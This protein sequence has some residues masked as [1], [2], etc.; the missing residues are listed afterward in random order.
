MRSVLVG[1]LALASCA[2]ANAW[3][4]DSARAVA[5]DEV[6]ASAVQAGDVPGAVALVITRDSVLYH[7]AFGLMDPVGEVM[8]GDAI[9]RIRSMTKPMTS[10]GIMML[11][12][13]GLIALDDPASRHLPELAGREVLVAVD[14]VERSVT[15]RPASREVTVRDLLR[16]TSGIGYELSNYDALRLSEYTDN[17]P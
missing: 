10:L 15:T 3:T 4:L 11:V 5:L 1:V 13:E 6:L 8:R 2:D 17:P 14:S 16:H 12:E 9:F 7:R